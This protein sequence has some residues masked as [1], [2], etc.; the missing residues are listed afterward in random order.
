MKDKL[1]DSQQFTSH[2]DRNVQSLIDR[3][4]LFTKKDAIKNKEKLIDLAKIK[5][6]L[7]IRTN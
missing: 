7:C 1:T 3:E 4:N 6:P 2:F 5:S